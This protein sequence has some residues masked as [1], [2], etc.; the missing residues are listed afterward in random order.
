MISFYFYIP[1]FDKLTELPEFCW[2]CMQFSNEDWHLVLT[3]LDIIVA[4]WIM[5]IV[6]VDFENEY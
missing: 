5:Y 1:V 4:K 6:Y 2:R 3:K